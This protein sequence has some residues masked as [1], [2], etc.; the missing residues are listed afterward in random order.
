M[1]GGGGER[2]GSNATHTGRWVPWPGLQQ[3]ALQHRPISAGQGPMSGLQQPGQL[4]L[5]LVTSPNLKAM[6]LLG[7]CGPPVSSAT[8]AS[9]LSPMSSRK[10]PLVRHRDL[11]GTIRSESVDPSQS[12]RVSRSESVGPSQSIRVSRSESVGL[13]QSI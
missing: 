7:R 8:R 5:R 11:M 2:G 9:P 13:S 3:L 1:W 4:L 6:R 12:V 10:K